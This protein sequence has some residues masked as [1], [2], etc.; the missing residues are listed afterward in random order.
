[1]KK[2]VLVMLSVGTT[3]IVKAQ[4]EI[5]TLSNLNKRY[6]QYNLSL[7]LLVQDSIL[8]QNEIDSLIDKR[9]ELEIK[10]DEYKQIYG[11]S[12]KLIAFKIK[13]IGKHSV[14][15]VEQDKTAYIY[16]LYQFYGE[17]LKP[18]RVVINE[19]KIG[20]LHERLKLIE[21]SMFRQ[22]Q[23]IIE[24]KNLIQLNK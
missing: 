1:M 2:I 20:D 4:T 21:Y 11:V 6:S 7:T 15:Y 10:Q 13:E 19:G 9:K 12:S 8:I 14:S 3:F 24:I 16:K 18:T 23:D 22:R 5:F 17:T